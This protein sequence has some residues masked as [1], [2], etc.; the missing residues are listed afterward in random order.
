MNFIFNSFQHI[1]FSMQGVMRPVGSVWVQ[2]PQTA[3]SVSNRKRFYSL[4]MDMSLTGPVRLPA[5]HSITL[6][7]I[8]LVEVSK[9]EDIFL[10]FSLKM[11]THTLWFLILSSS[12]IMKWWQDKCWKNNLH[13]VVLSDTLQVVCTS[14]SQCL[15]PWW[16]KI[17]TSLQI[18]QGCC[19]GC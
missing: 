1:S 15:Y 9:K 19:T 13:A 4:R 18:H 10:Y 14:F 2:T 3:C 8:R 12:L 11:K 6:T 16:L 7:Q 5:G 17:C